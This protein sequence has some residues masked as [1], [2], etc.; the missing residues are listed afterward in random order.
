MPSRAF[1]NAAIVIRKAWLVP[2][3]GPATRDG[4]YTAMNQRAAIA[5]FWGRSMCVSAAPPP[6]NFGVASLRL[7]DLSRRRATPFMSNWRCF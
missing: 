1:S 4:A 2:H 3:R 6:A 7:Q 5:A